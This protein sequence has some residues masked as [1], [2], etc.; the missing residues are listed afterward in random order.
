[1]AIDTAEKRRSAAGIAFHPLGPG[2]TPNSDKDTAWRQQAGWGYSGAVIAATRYLAK[3][4]TWE[5]T[6]A[7]GSTWEK[8]IAKGSTWEPTIDL[9]MTWE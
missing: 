8:T 1:M 4:M 5:P 3:S 7:L 2:V 9:E 6:I